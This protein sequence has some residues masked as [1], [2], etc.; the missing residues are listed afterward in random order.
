MK[1]RNP[2]FKPFALLLN[3]AAANLDRGRLFSLPLFFKFAV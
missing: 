3:S 1:Q 2:N